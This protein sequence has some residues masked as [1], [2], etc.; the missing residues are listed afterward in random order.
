L[1][2]RVEVGVVDITAVEAVLVD[3]VLAQ[4]YQ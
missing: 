2:L 3:F 1:W 4:V